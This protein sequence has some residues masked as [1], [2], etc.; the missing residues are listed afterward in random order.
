VS[1]ELVERESVGGAEFEVDPHGVESDHPED[2]QAQAAQEQEAAVASVVAMGWTPEEA[3]ALVCAVWNL[4]ILMYG[5]KWA[6]DPRETLGW[7]AS[8]AQ[9][10]DIYV[11]KGVG[12]AVQIGAGLLMIGNGLMYMVMRRWEVIKH[13][14]PIWAKRPTS[15]GAAVPTHPATPP[16]TPTSKPASNGR[17]EMPKDLIPTTNGD[18]LTGLGL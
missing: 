8:V 9:L 2:P 10:L 13:P 4:G 17:Y 11:P 15:E 16:Q 12:G 18:G 14:E 1:V 5:P 3:T 7:N 6:A